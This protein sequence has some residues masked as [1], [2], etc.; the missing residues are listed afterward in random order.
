MS[1]LTSKIRT[2]IVALASLGMVGLPSAQ[3]GNHNFAAAGNRMSSN[4]A[5][6]FIAPRTTYK[7]IT[8][9]NMGPAPKF[10]A[11]SSTTGT[12]FLS[13]FSGKATN[14]P[15]ALAKNLPLPPVAPGGAT[16]G[17]AR[18]WRNRLDSHASEFSKS[19]GVVN[20]SSFKRLVDQPMQLTPK[21]PGSSNQS[22][23]ILAGN[24]RLNTGADTGVVNPA[25]HT[26][27]QNNLSQKLLSAG[28]RVN[29]GN[30]NI[31]DK[32]LNSAAAAQ[33]GYHTDSW[34][35]G[36][37]AIPTPADIP[38]AGLGTVV[39]A[40]YEAVQ[41]LVELGGR[42][43]RFGADPS[44]SGEPSIS[45]V[46]T[47]GVGGEKQPS[48]A[49][50]ASG[51]LQ[52]GVTAGVQKYASPLKSA[53]DNSKDFNQ[54]KLGSQA[55]YLNP[56]ASAADKS[57]QYG[58]GKLGGQNKLLTPGTA[59]I[60]PIP[61][62]TGGDGAG[63]S[64]SGTT[65]GS[66]GTRTYPFPLPLPIGPVVYGGSQTSGVVL[67]SAAASVPADTS[68]VSADVTTDE[69]VVTSADLVVED[70]Q[71]D[72]PAT[73]VAGPAYRVK[74]RNQGSAAATKF[75][76]AVLA[77]LD[78]KLADDAPRAVV[79]VASLAAGQVGEVVLRLPQRALAMQT[80]AEGQPTAFTHLFIAVD[81][82]NSVAEV[83]ETNNTAVVGR[84]AVEA[85]V[86]K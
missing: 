85:P 60:P 51:R 65:G 50:R 8:P 47:L 66:T 21:L 19:Q 59:T 24:G 44:T 57:N 84:A 64:Q 5:G 34:D 74:F 9:S 28:N 70:I 41:P 32:V 45:M 18:A 15:S 37:I 26:V 78:A 62:G 22:A 77:G 7:S 54:G 67:N 86:V 76:V 33:G 63:T 71:L 82:A 53:A 23:R 72:A 4:V 17:K 46:A 10:N 36:P 43:S 68:A 42:N 1:S 25:T 75:Q 31:P 6:R 69:D 52:T 79:E 35:I 38:G 83:D 20:S 3:A 13:K 55:K 27:L 49:E 61:H 2:G 73:L 29:G 56:L 39:G 14:L 80:A 12:K 11:T 81:L 40:L 16:N 30:K 48:I 58:H